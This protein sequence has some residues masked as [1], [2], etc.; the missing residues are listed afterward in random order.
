M[1][2]DSNV[3]RVLALDGLPKDSLKTFHSFENITT[4]NLEDLRQELGMSSWAA[5]IA[6]NERFGR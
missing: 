4:V 1:K 5:R 3:K 2:S 6:Y